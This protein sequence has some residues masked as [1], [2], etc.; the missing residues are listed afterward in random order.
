MKNGTTAPAA[1]LVI[2]AFMLGTLGGRWARPAPPTGR[3]PYEV[4]RRLCARGLCLRVVPASPG[5]LFP[6]VYLTTTHQTRDQLVGLP[7][8]IDVAAR[9]RGTVLCKEEAPGVELLERDPQRLLRH[10]GFVF[11]GDPELLRQIAEVLRR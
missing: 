5:G 7:W 3:G 1:V 11:Y 4:A 10:G 9:W 6:G 2:A 8:S